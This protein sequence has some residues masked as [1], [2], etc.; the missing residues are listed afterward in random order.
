MAWDDAHTAALHDEDRVQALAAE[1]ELAGVVHEVDDTSSAEA[2][3]ALGRLRLAEARRLHLIDGSLVE[4][5]ER[6]QEAVTCLQAVKA[7]ED[8]ATARRRLGLIARDLGLY[9]ITRDQAARERLEAAEDE[10]PHSL[11]CLHATLVLAEAML[12]TGQAALAES[13]VQTTYD[14]VEHTWP[15]NF[16]LRHL[17]RRIRCDVAQ[18]RGVD[19]QELVEL[20]NDLDQFTEVAHEAELAA[21]RAERDHGTASDEDHAPLRPDDPRGVLA[22]HRRLVR[23]ERFRDAEALELVAAQWAEQDGHELSLWRGLFYC[24]HARRE[25]CQGQP[26]PA[27]S[28]MTECIEI[29]RRFEPSQFLLD[30]FEIAAEISAELGLAGLRLLARERQVE[31]AEII[32]GE[33]SLETFTAQLHHAQALAEL[34]ESAEAA[35][36]LHRTLA[37]LRH[38]HPEAHDELREGTAALADVLAVIPGRER[39]SEILAGRSDDPNALRS[40][41]LSSAQAELDALVGLDAI[42]EQVRKMVAFLAVQQERQRL[43]AQPAVRSHHLVFVGPPG[44]GKTTVARI[45]GKFFYGLGILPTDHV[46]EVSRGD[47]VGEHIGE[48]A[49]KTDDVID[50]ALDGVLFVDEAYALAGEGRDFGAEAIATL[51]KRMEDDRHRLVLI[52]AGYDR[53]MDLLLDSNPGLRSRFTQVLRFPAYDER[54]LMRILELMVDQQGYALSPAASVA[55]QAICRDMAGNNTPTFGHAREI[56]HVVDDAIVT[57]ADRIY[58]IGR[59]LE[60]DALS[61]LEPADLEWQRRSSLRPALGFGR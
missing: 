61:L 20:R 35:R 37:R 16:D 59:P 57:Q 33:A 26:V 29:F 32:T 18:A 41:A 5:L 23:A 39:E 10:G 48:T 28:A 4:A 9:E 34:H 19:A 40:A 45:M 54:E 38:H 17:A 1:R 2:L 6:A 56:R 50:R 25:M 8:L 27:L 36:L 53:E 3:V 12:S 49:V 42:K 31:V 44:T 55:A 11:N 46:L 43:G 52:M 30:A 15:E 7:A 14:L 47:L 22:E 24:M 58:R 51:L 21:L 60:L 13:L